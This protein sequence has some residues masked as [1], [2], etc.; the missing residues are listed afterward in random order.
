[1]SSLRQFTLTCTTLALL[2][3]LPQ[4]QAAQVDLPGQL[5]AARQEG[6]I[7]T[8]WALNKHLSPFNLSVKVEHGVAVLE[9]KVENQ[10][11]RE[12]AEQIALDTA[13]IERVDNRLSVDDALSEHPG[14]PQPIA[15]RLQDATLTATIKS[16]L[17]WNSVTQGLDISVSTAEGVVTLKGRAQTADAKQL[18]GRLA[19][20]TDGVYV[21]NNLISPLPERSRPPTIPRPPSAMPGSL[22]RSRPA[23]CSTANSMASLSMSRPSRAWSP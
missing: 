21:V 19:T 3:V 18:A 20:D 9:G 14:A 22:A 1:M 6:S 2:A 7:W 15:Q 17:L 5:A 8:A 4:A 11:D 10:V 13:G 16:K 23:W 12:L